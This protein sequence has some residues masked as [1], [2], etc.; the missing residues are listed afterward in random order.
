M[1]KSPRTGD[2][3]R[4]VSSSDKSRRGDTGSY[5]LTL[6]NGKGEVKIPIDVTVIDR[7]GTPEGPLK[8]SE[9][10]K[11]ACLLTWR[12]PLDNGGCAIDKYIIEKQDVARGDWSPV[13]E[14]N[15]DT[16]TLRVIRLTPG[17]EYMFRV[18]AVNK[19]GESDNLETTGSTLAKNPY[20]EPSAPSKPE[21]LDWD[22]NRVDLQWQA[23]V[24]WTMV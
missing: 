7:P 9:V 5:E 3:N 15:G 6:K 18:R 20:D 19:E 10:R 8:I 11:D 13:N 22:K 24:R 12:P 21:V 16:T 1:E 17:K 14:V 4:D 23:P 2:V